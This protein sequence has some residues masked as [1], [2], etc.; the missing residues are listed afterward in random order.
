MSKVLCESQDLTNIADAIREK[1]N[2]TDTMAVSSMAYNINSISNNGISDE[3][4][5]QIEQ[6]TSNINQ[7]Q[8][9][10]EKRYE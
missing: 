2:T 1:T 3:Y 7:L 8:Q 9:E 4:I 10:M 6:N 5:A